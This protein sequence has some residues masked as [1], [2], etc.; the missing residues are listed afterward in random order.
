MPLLRQCA[1]QIVTE[2]RTR[3][4]GGFVDK[5]KV[6]TLAQVIGNLGLNSQIL[7]ARDDSPIQFNH[8]SIWNNIH[9]ATT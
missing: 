8:T 1:I 3:A 9:A 7:F 5:F 6:E 2:C 4:I